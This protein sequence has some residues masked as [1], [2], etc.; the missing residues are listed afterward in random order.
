MHWLDP[1]YLPA[2]HGSVAAVIPNEAGDIDGL[3]LA[4]GQEVHLPPHFSPALRRRL[5]LGDTVEI[6][7]VKPRDVDLLV[8]VAVRFEDGA[9]VSGPPR[10]GKKPR[11]DH[12]V[13]PQRWSY[14]GTLA[15]L[16]HGPHGDVHGLLLEDGVVGR[17]P[18][19][20]ERGWQRQLQPGATLRLEGRWQD[21]PYGPLIQV[22]RL[23]G[24]RGALRAIK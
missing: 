11:R 13:D 15:R 5:K 6:R 18:P 24:P 10:Q 12:A 17:F 1:D 22:D 19:H 23:G 16:L 4:S 8:A 20:A 14:E 7:G 21:T 9:E 3:L 2:T